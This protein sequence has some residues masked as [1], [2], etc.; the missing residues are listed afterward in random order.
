MSMS[1]SGSRSYTGRL[2]TSPE[3]AV[4]L[5]QNFRNW[6]KVFAV[7]Y[8]CIQTICGS[9][10]PKGENFPQVPKS[11]K[12][13][14]EEAGLDARLVGATIATFLNWFPAEV[15][16][17]RNEN[18]AV[19]W[20]EALDRFI[21]YW[22]QARLGDISDHVLET[23][24]T[25]TLKD[26]VSIIDRRAK[27]CESGL[28][29]NVIQNRIF[30]MLEYK[31]CFNKKAESWRGIIS[32]SFGTS[33]KG[34]PEW[35]LLIMECLLAYM[36]PMD[37]NTLLPIASV[38]RH[39]HS[40][41]HW[42]LAVEGK[43]GRTPAYM[44]LLDRPG[45]I[46][47][48]KY[49]DSILK[50][51]AGIGSKKEKTVL[52][53]EYRDFF[54]GAIESLG[55]FQ[56]E[57][58]GDL[59]YAAF[60]QPWG[61]VASHKSN[62]FN[63]VVD[64]L[65]LFEDNKNLYSERKDEIELLQKFCDEMRENLEV[66]DYRIRQHQDNGLKEFLSFIGEYSLE[67]ALDK[68]EDA[69]NVRLLRNSNRQFLEFLHRNKKTSED[70]EAIAEAVK[71]HWQQEKIDTARLGYLADVIKNP[72]RP[73]Y[74][75][76]KPACKISLNKGIKLKLRLITDAGVVDQEF[77]VQAARLQ[78]EVLCARPNDPEVEVPRNTK[79][80][81]PDGL[82]AVLV[83]EKEDHAVTVFSRMPSWGDDA[84]WAIGVIPKI[85][86]M[87]VGHVSNPVGMG[88]DLG[89]RE[90]A[91]FTVLQHQKSRPKAFGFLD[92]VI[93]RL[94]SDGSGVPQSVFAFGA[95]A[96]VELMALCNNLWK[97]YA[98]EGSTPPAKKMRFANAVSLC[99]SMLKRGMYDQVTNILLQ[100]IEL[101]L[102]FVSPHLSTRTGK[103][104]FVPVGKAWKLPPS[105]GALS[106]DRMEMY[107]SL[108]NMV[109][110]LIG[111]AEDQEVKISDQFADIRTRLYNK[112]TNLRN[113]R[114]RI[115]G[116]MILSAAILHRV[117]FIAVEDLDV[118]SDRRK[119]K[120]I[121]EG[122][123]R[124]YAGRIIK[125]LEDEAPMHGIRTIKVDPRYGS[126]KDYDG[127]ELCRMTIV[128]PQRIPEVTP[129]GKRY[130]SIA[131]IEK[132]LRT[133]LSGTGSTLDDLY[134]RE[135]QK[136]LSDRTFTATIKE[137]KAAG[138]ESLMVPWRGGEF[139]LSKLSHDPISSDILAS[140]VIAQRGYEAWERISKSR[141]A[142]AGKTD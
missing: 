33:K 117:N 26:G 19:T 60:T 125:F 70:T 75:K 74:G 133:F 18:H 1:K 111:V 100:D 123:A 56:F 46:H 114:A 128:N 124:W 96:P 66:E 37:D 112:Q 9:F 13:Q 139:V 92:H 122:V 72:L 77:D 90:P 107:R 86:Y 71:W 67:E 20:T 55:L 50:R 104:N 54:I 52:S 120:F 127:S 27:F 7:G 4:L 53:K 38:V 78:R 108:L 76:S 10:Y 73:V 141:A 138:T 40:K 80:H 129:R 59:V 106:S 85:F 81:N 61:Q 8:D 89:W 91:A 57:G 3:T 25:L 42:P 135:T 45:D 31:G 99:V 35:D 113:E 14:I 134:R 58:N 34:N 119:K 79:Y 142:V 110:T 36:E 93:T 6:Q 16:H 102:S 87:P 64:Q 15:L 116:R 109:G 105:Q 44:E 69:L 21:T 65:C 68:T 17:K 115:T 28:N 131:S 51:M 29:P 83:G 121:N 118:Q 12:D 39:L 97:R 23:L 5:E 62:A 82:E 2:R 132:R 137:A 101:L 140:H 30:S 130:S 88:I 48:K 22:R 103:S 47:V 94:K 32:E 98:S 63:R 11:S 49:R 24:P 95:D 43:Q 136:L 84:H 126:H 41:G